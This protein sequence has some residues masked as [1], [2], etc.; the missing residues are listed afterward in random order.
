MVRKTSEEG[1]KLEKGVVSVGAIH[2]CLTKNIKLHR[3]SREL[4]IYLLHTGQSSLPPI[5]TYFLNI[6]LINYVAWQHILKHR[7]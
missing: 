5:C 2:A 6:T 1:V 4:F 7:K 3:V